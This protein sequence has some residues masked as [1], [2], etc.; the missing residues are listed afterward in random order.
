MDVL[1]GADGRA[2][3]WAGLFG[4]LE[5]VTTTGIGFNPGGR[6]RPKHLPWHQIVALTGAPHWDRSHHTPPLWQP[7]DPLPQPPRPLPP[8]VRTG[9]ASP[10]CARYRRPTTPADPTTPGPGRSWGTGVAGTAAL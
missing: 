3:R 8:P 4:T 2:D 6:H 1:C 5:S 7:Y 10:P 9:H